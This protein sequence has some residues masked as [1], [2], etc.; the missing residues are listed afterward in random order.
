MRVHGEA[1]SQAKV[2]NLELAVSVDKQIARLKITME[3]I[4]RVD[5]FQAT[6][7]LVDKGLEVG[8]GQRLAGPYDGGQIALHELCANVSNAL[9]AIVETGHTLVEIAFVEVVRTGD[10]H[11]V[12]TCDLYHKVQ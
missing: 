2:A 5:V 12:E 1:S 8:V 6:Q 11:V 3:D 4:G 9:V 7:N 10:V